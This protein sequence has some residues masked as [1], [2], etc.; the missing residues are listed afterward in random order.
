MSLNLKRHLPVLKLLRI[1]SPQIRH[2]VLKNAGD[3]LLNAVC[4]ICHNVASSNVKFDKKCYKK[5]MKYKKAIRKLASARKDKRKSQLYKKY[6]YQKGGAFQFLPL[7]LTPIIGELTHY[8][9]RK[10]LN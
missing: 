8:I 5:L 3:G 7:L 2:D 4:E 1:V 10:F 9:S 6:L